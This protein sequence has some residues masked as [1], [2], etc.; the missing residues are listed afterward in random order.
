[1]KRMTTA[2]LIAAVALAAPAALAAHALPAIGK[3][4]PDFS[5]TTF[6]GKVISSKDLRGQVVILNFWATWCGPCRNELPL[7]DAY[8]RAQQRFGFTVVAVTTEDSVEPALLAPLQKRLAMRLAR[9]FRGRYADPEALPTNIV[10]DR[11]GLVRYAEVGAFSLDALNAVI[12]PLL[13]EPAP[14]TAAPAP[15]APAANVAAR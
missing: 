8:L 5:V 1:M 3:P 15:T 6:D 10:I 13:K 7:L 14:D 9:R 12:V 11:A 4:A 2:A